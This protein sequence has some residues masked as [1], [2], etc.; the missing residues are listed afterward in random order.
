MVNTL[1]LQGEKCEVASQREKSKYGAMFRVKEKW[2][3][4]VRE[5][6]RVNVKENRTGKDLYIETKVDEIFM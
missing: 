1:Q 3:F 5:R 2:I 4:L 6:K